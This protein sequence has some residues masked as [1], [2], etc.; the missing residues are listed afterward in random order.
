MVVAQVQDGDLSLDDLKSLAA[1]YDPQEHEAPITV[2]HPKDN[3]PAF[4][5]VKRLYL[6]GTQLWADMDLLSEFDELLQRGIYKKRSIA[7]YLA[8][9]ALRHI[10]FLGG[11][12]PRIK[13]MPDFVFSDSLGEGHRIVELGE[14][15]QIND[16]FMH[17]GE[18]LSRLR[19]RLIEE[20]GLEAVDK[21]IGKWTLDDLQRRIK[22]DSENPVDDLLP[23]FSEMLKEEQSMSEKNLTQDQHQALLD[24]ALQKQKADL[25]AQFSEK[26]KALQ[27]KQADLEKKINDLEGQVGEFA[28]KAARAEVVSFCEKQIS[29]GRMA[30]KE[31]DDFVELYMELPESAREKQRKLV[32]NR[33]KVLEFGEDSRAAGGPE[34]GKEKL[35]DVDKELGISKEDLEKYGDM[36]GFSLAAHQVPIGGE[37]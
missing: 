20:W 12:P 9:K 36:K 25:T 33:T 30:P 2:G 32:E 34:P 11:T 17:I 31:K 4:G 10:G 8:T 14:L 18:V 5:W 3:S 37:A 29:E 16:R 22:P 1:N 7:Y 27:D 35:S 15:D 26:E 13:G 21:V 24:A 19:D 28:E 6:K 23:T